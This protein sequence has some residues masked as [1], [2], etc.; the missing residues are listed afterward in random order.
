MAIL[1][2]LA[3]TAYHARAGVEPS[4]GDLIV[5]H[6]VLGRLLA[7]VCLLVGASLLSSGSAIP[8]APTA[9]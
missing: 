2:A 8:R 1:L 4:Q 3:A 5:G 7:R 9:R 6:G